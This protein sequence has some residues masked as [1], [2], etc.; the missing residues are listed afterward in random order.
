MMRPMVF[1]LILAACAPEQPSVQPKPP[2]PTPRVAAPPAEPVQQGPVVT[3]RQR[4]KMYEG[5]YGPE[6]AI[7]TTFRAPAEHDAYVLNCNGSF[8]IG[9]QR[10]VGNDWEHVWAPAMA[11]C[12]SEPIV[13]PAGKTLQKTLVVESGA[14]GV[15]S[16]RVMER[17]IVSGTYR[18][19]WHGVL[20]AYDPNTSPPGPHLPL[21]KRVSAPFFLEATPPLDPAHPSPAQRPAEVQSV[22]PAHGARVAADNARVRVQLSGITG[23]PH[24]YVDGDWVEPIR[25]NNALEFSPPSGRWKP[26][27]HRLR[28]IY[29]NA[30]RKLLWYAWSFNVGP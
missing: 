27:R 22:E 21:E 10:P 29:Q 11:A 30:Q 2:T 1:I 28:V 16:S 4:Y 5:P 23:V 7:E 12:M 26:G 25:R 19:V 14:G 9:L 15:I 20:A 3:D 17:E 13:V 24:L 6:V 18:V 8:P